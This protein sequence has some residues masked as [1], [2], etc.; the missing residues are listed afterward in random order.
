MRRWAPAKVNLYLHVGPPRAD[1]R[2]PLD[3]L[4]V[5][6]DHRAAD[7]VELIPSRGDT[8]F[9]VSPGFY[10]GDM[11]EDNLCLRALRA[12]ERHAGR[13]LPSAITL[14]K[15]LPVAGGVGGGSADA[16]AILHLGN[17]VHGLGL[18]TVELADIGAS[19]GGDVPVC[20]HG[21]PALMRDDGARVTP[22]AG[23]FPSLPAVLVNPGIAC[24][25][26]AVFQAFDRAGMG[27]GFAECRPPEAV[28]APDLIEA[29]AGF[30]NDLWDAAVDQVPALRAV[31][32]RIGTHV[33]GAPVRLSGSGATSFALFET[34]AEARAA[35]RRLSLAEPGWWVA[36]TRL[37]AAAPNGGSRW[38]M[39][40]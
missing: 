13:A 9:R 37:G 3:S 1:G 39:S 17:E 26:G 19:L 38:I 2:H 22:I 11:G 15:Q 12:L 29:L 24:P 25:T 34:D 36:E 30:R 18:K 31:R 27:Q 14:E 8:L 5:F 40:G 7:R 35:A 4:V 6:A 16:A 28:T 20:V 32:E 33:S 23:D 10:A 21:V